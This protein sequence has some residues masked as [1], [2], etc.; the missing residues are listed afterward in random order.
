MTPTR[1]WGLVRLGSRD[2]APLSLLVLAVLAL[3]QWVIRQRSAFGPIDELQHFNYLTELIFHHRIPLPGDVLTQEALRARACHPVAAE[4]VPPCASPSFDPAAFP[5]GALSTAG[6]YPLTYY[7]PTALVAGFLSQVLGVDLVHAARTASSLWLAGGAAATYVLGRSFR[8]TP[9]ATAAVTFLVVLAPMVAYQGSSVN[10]DAASLLSGAAAAAAWLALRGRARPAATVGL[11]AALTAVAWVKPNLI[12][13]PVAIAVTELII[14]MVASGSS[15]PLRRETWT[16]ST[17]L[18]RVVVATAVAAVLGVAWPA[19][20]SRLGTPEPQFGT[21]PWSLDAALRGWRLSLTPLT[22]MP[23]L[24]FINHGVWPWLGTVADTLV[25]VGMLGAVLLARQLSRPDDLVAAAGG[26]PVDPLHALGLLGVVSLVLAAPVTY[27]LVAASGAFLVY[28][29]RYS[30]FVAPL[31]VAALVGT[32]AR[33]RR[34]ARAT[35][36]H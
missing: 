12:V 13:V 14:T 35:E 34:R 25:L 23:K 11:A 30:L 17:P 21:V 1:S 7:L 20:F 4:P 19:V 32:V 31:G 6:G 26:D 33:A 10:P 15:A 29:P 16:R 2:W 3:A 9:W 27:L 8:G 22:N 24:G 18:R 28:P 36:P 5:H